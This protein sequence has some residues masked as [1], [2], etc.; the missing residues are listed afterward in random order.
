MSLVLVSIV[1]QGPEGLD[2][3]KSIVQKIARSSQLVEVGSILNV[4]R[5]KNDVFIQGKEF[6]LTL[7]V[8]QQ[9]QGFMENLKSIEMEVLSENPS[10]LLVT[11]VL[12][13]ENLSLLSPDLVLPHPD[14]RFD[15]VT[16]KLAAEIWGD[17]FHPIAKR[18]LQEIVRDEGEPT[19]GV[20]FCVQG[21]ELFK[22]G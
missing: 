17:Y 15:G 3:A 4:S 22:K 18:T 9:P 5:E 2:A 14:L 11:K 6:V 10:N 19:L 13:W 21:I 8:D 12:A 20:E 1:I 7:S 16:L